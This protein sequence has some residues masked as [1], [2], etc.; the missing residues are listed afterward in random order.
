ML[1]ESAEMD[2]ASTQ[3]VIRLCRTAKQSP[4]FPGVPGPY[5]S[6]LRSRD[7]FQGSLSLY[8]GTDLCLQNTR[9]AVF[10]LTRKKLSPFLRLFGS[11]V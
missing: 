5:Y 9:A 7:P 8:D 11:A 4:S 2:R 10:H 1:K 6:V 3:K